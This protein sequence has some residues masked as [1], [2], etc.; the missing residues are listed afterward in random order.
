MMLNGNDPGFKVTDY[1]SN[2]VD[3]ARSGEN[4][5]DAVNLRRTDEELNEVSDM[6]ED[7]IFRW[8]KEVMGMAEEVA[9]A[10][11]WERSKIELQLGDGNSTLMEATSEMYSKQ[12]Q[13]DNYDREHGD[14]A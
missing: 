7:K 2:E 11:G 14:E 5:E 8:N 3:E 4:G 13:D 10:R 6:I 12:P 9:E 1:E